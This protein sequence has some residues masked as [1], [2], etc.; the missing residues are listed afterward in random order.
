[1]QRKDFAY[2]VRNDETPLDRFRTYI[3]FTL[4]DHVLTLHMNIIAAIFMV[5]KRW[6]MRYDAFYLPSTKLTLE[7]SWATEDL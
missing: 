1:M 5:L 7:E 3:P 4:H 6:P 2:Q